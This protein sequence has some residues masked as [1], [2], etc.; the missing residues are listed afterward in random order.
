ML[1]IV[2]QLTGCGKGDF[3]LTCLLVCFM[4]RFM[5]K[6]E[7]A[8]Q[9]TRGHILKVAKQ[10]FIRSGV[11]GSPT[12]E[13]ARLAGIAHGTLFFHFPTREDLVLEVFDRE[14]VQVSED[15]HELLHKQQDIGRL[16]SLYLTYLEQE[17]PFFA[18]MAREFPLFSEKLQRRILFRQAG[19]RSYFGLELGRG[20]AL[21]VYRK[22]DVTATL[23]FLFGSIDYLLGRKAVLVGQGSVIREHRQGILDSFLGLVMAREG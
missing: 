6:R 16:L 17:E 15:L 23:T 4:L 21:G 8:R 9:R 5:N 19:I 20:M 18:V 7:Q 13:I 22:L 11:L 1:R 2:A 3:G 14:L 12:K 10:L